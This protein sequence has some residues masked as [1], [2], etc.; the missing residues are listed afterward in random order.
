MIV[1]S[2]VLCQVGAVQKDHL[3]FN[4]VSGVGYKYMCGRCNSVYYGEM[5]KH[6]KV[7][8]GEHIRISP[9]TFKEV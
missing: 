2:L 8:S 5:D 1:C 3:P 4:L 9:L 6:L 7:R